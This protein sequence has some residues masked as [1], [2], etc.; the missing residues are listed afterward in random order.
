VV[1]GWFRWALTGHGQPHFALV[2][3]SAMM[4]VLLLV[5]G[6][7]YFQRVEETVVDVL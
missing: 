4:M 7:L 5:A 6:L 3:A 2:L 1:I